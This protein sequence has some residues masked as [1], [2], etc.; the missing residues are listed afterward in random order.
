VGDATGQ[1]PDGLQLLGLPELFLAPD[2]G[3]FGLLALRDLALEFVIGALKV[4]RPRQ[5]P[6]L[7][8]RLEFPKLSV[9]F[10]N[11][12]GPAIDLRLHP[13]RA[14]L[15]FF[16]LLG[17]LAPLALQPNEF[18][19]V[20]H[21]VDDVDNLIVRPE[22]GRV[23]GAPVPLLELAPLRFRLSNVVLLNG[24]GVGPLSREHPVERVAKVLGARCVRIV[25]V[26]RKDIE[27]MPAENV[28]APRH[29]GGGV[30]VAHGHDR[31]IRGQHQVE[32]RRRFEE[33]AEIRF[34]RIRAGRAFHESPLAA[35]SLAVSIDP[36]GAGGSVSCTRDTRRRSHPR[37]ATPPRPFVA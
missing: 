36:A 27:E 6:L 1:P 13:A 9:R 4:R 32:A 35:T 25:G 11:F 29:R 21:A 15:Q 2:Q 31:E 26:V 24:H 33:N 37:G 12:L 17:L 20:L 5:N 10:L 8:L 7:E 18:G 34:R 28:R 22:H 23:H 14:G 3:L 19:D 30:G 16:G